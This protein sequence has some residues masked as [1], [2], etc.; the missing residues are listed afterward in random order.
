M[1]LRLIIR[2]AAAESGDTKPDIQQPSTPATPI[3]KKFEDIDPETQR[4][5]YIKPIIDRV[6]QVLGTSEWKKI[7]DESAKKFQVFKDEYNKLQGNI[8]DIQDLIN[9]IIPDQPQKQATAQGKTPAEKTAKQKFISPITKHLEQYFSDINFSADQKNFINKIVKQYRFFALQ[10]ALNKGNVILDIANTIIKNKLFSN[11]LAAYGETEFRKTLVD[12]L[13]S[14]TTLTPE[15]ENI[16]KAPAATATSDKSKVSEPA[17]E[18]SPFI[19]G[20]NTLK[21][22]FGL[23]KHHV[24]VIRNLNID[25]QRSS[26][27]LEEA[28]NLRIPKF[29]QNYITTKI[30]DAIDTEVFNDFSP[31]GKNNLKKALNRLFMNI[32][33]SRSVPKPDVAPAAETTPAATT[34]E[35]SKPAQAADKG[36]SFPT[37]LERQ[38]TAD[39]AEKKRE[40]EGYEIESSVNAVFQ[41]FYDEAQ[42][43]LEQGAANKIAKKALDKIKTFVDV[44]SLDRRTGMYIGPKITSDTVITSITDAAKEIGSQIDRNVEQGIL[45]KIAGFITSKLSEKGFIGEKQ[46]DEILSEIKK[47]NKTVIYEGLFDKFLD[48]QHETPT[49]PLFR[50]SRKK[51]ILND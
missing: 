1:A 3:S 33:L 7:E 24:D 46:A 9:R 29:S 47:S 27:T 4:K 38:K 44:H 39:Q 51:I 19:T 42:Q 48:K 2:E 11:I 5:V 49:A 41:G 36:R 25:F 30:N 21:K 13:G 8:G 35:Q 15:E 17:K 32:Y 12:M 20:L 14:L 22:N 31:T 28:K 16:L 10:E 40:K 43:E 50:I 18:K 37:G 34:P 23:K 26:Y 6:K 45:Q